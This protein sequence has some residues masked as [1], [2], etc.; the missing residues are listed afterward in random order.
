MSMPINQVMLHSS[1]TRIEREREL[2]LQRLLLCYRSLCLFKRKTL[3][4]SHSPSHPM[5][6]LF[7]RKR[8][9]KQTKWTFNIITKCWKVL[10][11]R[12]MFSSNFHIRSSK[13][14]REKKKK[15]TRWWIFLFHLP[16]NWFDLILIRFWYYFIWIFF[17]LFGMYI[18]SSLSSFLR[19]ILPPFP[20]LLYTSYSS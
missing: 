7:S 5:P 12:T 1:R 6:T 4:Q 15:K 11:K 19:V 3:R 18:Q 13:I 2:R 17:F 20:R 16:L 14:S 8:K 9:Q 10:S